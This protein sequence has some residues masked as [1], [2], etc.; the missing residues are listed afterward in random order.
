MEPIGWD[1]VVG[2]DRLPYLKLSTFAGGQSSYDRSGENSDFS[3]FLF[4]DEHDDQVM[5]D[6]EGPGTV[7][8]LWF[9]GFDPAAANLKI[10]VDG[11][12]PYVATLAAL[13]SGTLPGFPSPLVGVA[14]NGGSYAYVPITFARSLRLTTNGRAG[15]LGAF[16][17]NVG[18]HLFPAGTAVPRW[19]D[20]SRSEAAEAL[21][22]TET[23]GTR[24]GAGE[25]AG[26]RS[27][28]AHGIVDLDALTGPGAVESIR[29]RCDEMSRLR[30]LWLEIWWDDD[31]APSVA[32]PIKMLAGHGHFP[33][34]REGASL[35]AGLRDGWYYLQL[36]MP[37][38]QRATLRLRNPTDRPLDDVA[39]AIGHGPFAGD[40]NR[41]GR[42]RTQY[43]RHWPTD[44]RSLQ[45]LDVEG[46]GHFV[47][48]VVSIEGPHVA[49][50]RAATCFHVNAL[51]F[52]EGDERFYVDDA[53]TPAIIGTGLEDFFNGAWYF[54]AGP[55]DSA[56]AGCTLV[57][58]DRDHGRVSAYRFFLQDAVPFRKHLRFCIER[59]PDNSIPVAAWTL[60]FYYYQP[61]VRLLPHDALVIG[62]AASEAAHGYAAP[63]G[64]DAVGVGAARF[65]EADYRHVDAGGT[66]NE[67]RSASSFHLAIPPDNDGIVLRRIGDQ[68]HA[69]RAFVSVDGVPFGFW[70]RAKA[71][72]FRACEDDL[73]LPPA[74]TR[75][76]AALG[77]RIAWATGYPPWAESRYTAYALRTQGWPGPSLSSPRVQPGVEIAAVSRS[78]DRL[79]LFAPDVHGRV[80]TAAWE[81]ARPTWYM[82]GAVSP[83]V[84]DP[85]TGVGAVSRST[86]KLDVFFTD[87]T[88]ALATA[89]WEPARAGWHGGPIAPRLRPGSGGVPPALAAAGGVVAAS[90]QADH[91]DVFAPA[92]DGRLHV[93]AWPDFDPAHALPGRDW[94]GAWGL[95]L[96]THGR[97]R[98]SVISRAP[99]RL[100]AFATDAAGTVRTVAW[101]PDHGWRSWAIADRLAPGAAR[102]EVDPG[103]I[104]TV[105]SRAADHL[106]IFV[107]DRFGG[108][109][110]AAWQPGAPYWAGWWRLPMVTGVRGCAA[111]VVCRNRDGAGCIDLFFTGP[112][113]TVWSS[114]WD[115][116][117]GWAGFPIKAAREY[118][119]LAPGTPITVVSRRTDLMDLYAAG[120]D[121]RIWTT[122]WDPVEMWRPWWPIGL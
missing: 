97:G 73:F 87:A 48:T 33:D 17:Y 12:A 39:F 57:R 101:E 120:E 16:Y 65:F 26:T 24:V 43:A 29:L 62:D 117:R 19:T 85:A 1:A 114:A 82:L 104:V 9:T 41:V 102:P 56:V 11:G 34:A 3:V 25:L 96:W 51:C 47:G 30:E 74:I 50:N 2:L 66:F 110:S 27:V 42:L 55:F 86:D 116:A 99:D 53:R 71:G 67:R 88:G 58:D 49:D 28:P 59:G 80:V 83:H 20:A 21:W 115:A 108:V 107:I 89:A 77:L 113:G 103:A 105:V 44:R 119:T 111:N 60:A 68:L 31:V 7:Y 45:V 72:P 121:G 64:G 8:R 90:R 122:A 36:P 14:S 95:D 106:D 81:P 79:D 93:V 84:V 112:D 46:C 63:S 76:K 118:P 94:V 92:A 69:Q 23:F 13:F 37:F 10:Y 22:S 98:A 61:F 32:A 75:G 109:W 91:L 35:V 100:D 18:Y 70:N 5:L 40:F 6:L 78:E 15:G 52:L 38:A 4:K 54:N